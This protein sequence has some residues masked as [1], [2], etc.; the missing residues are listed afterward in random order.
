MSEY[1][2]QTQ[3][4][5]AKCNCTLE[6][7][8]IESHQCD[9]DDLNDRNRTLQEELKEMHEMVEEKTIKNGST[10]QQSRRRFPEVLIPT[11]DTPGLDF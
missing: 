9:N 11:T 3:L 10:A 1:M 5:Y 2:D 7:S 6:D 8:D 4:T